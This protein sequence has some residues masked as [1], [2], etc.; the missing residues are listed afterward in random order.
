VNRIVRTRKGLIPLATFI[1]VVVAAV[2]ARAQRSGW[3]PRSTVT[4]VVMLGTG[5][6]APIP[7]KMG[8]AVAI[9]VNG[10]PYLVDAGVGVVRRAAAAGRTVKGLEMTKLQR[11]FL[12]HLHTDHT[13]GLPDLIF[14]PWILGRTAPLE[15]FGPHGT[16]AMTSHIIEAWSEDNAVRTGGLE[17]GNRTGNK[18]N[19]HEIVEGVVYQDSN[20]KV[21]A[22]LVPHGEWRESFAYR[23]ETPDRVI[24][25]SGDERP[26]DAIVRACNGCDMLLH[27]VY[28]NLGYNKSDSAWKEYVRSAHTSTSEL[29]LIASK[30]RPRTLILYHQMY[31]GGPADTD[32][33]LIREIAAGWKGRV[34]AA[35]DLDIY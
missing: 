17:R 18:V 6:P 14:T 8:A 1:L 3:P 7:E 31:F 27:E 19:A 22:F 11:V 23:F 16:A 25:V 33:E 32:A 21:T 15:V 24:V 12:T 35:K 2:N 34:I 4:K 30:A 28:S 26:G 9:V 10:T 29:A 5:N 13:I 20:I